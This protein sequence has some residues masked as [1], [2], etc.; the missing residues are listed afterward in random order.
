[1]A[2]D[3]TTASA[4]G[5]TPGF[6]SA[7]AGL[8]REPPTIEGTATETPAQGSAPAAAR[9]PAPSASN[10][11]K[12]IGAGMA[13]SLG[14]AVGAVLALAAT[15]ALPSRDTPPDAAAR[16]AALERKAA[17]PATDPALAK[18]VGEAEATAKAAADAARSAS[19]TAKAA[20]SAAAAAN[21]AAT[22][23]K[24]GLAGTPSVDVAALTRRIEALEQ[25]PT[26]S[27]DPLDAK[28]AQLAQTSDAAAR[29]GAERLSALE[30][31]MAQ[32]GGQRDARLAALEQAQ[33]EMVARADQRVAGYDALLREQS[34]RVDARLSA[35]EATSR[36]ASAQAAQRLAA[37]E[38]GSKQSTDM[39]QARLAAAEAT[40]RESAAQVSQR[41]AALD[42]RIKSLDVKP[43][44]DQLGGLDQKVSTIDGR[45]GAV[46][47][48]AAAQGEELKAVAAGAAQR[49]QSYVKG[50]RS[51]ASALSAEAIQRAVVE[52]RPYKTQLDALA[53]SGVPA[54]ALA[55]LQPYAAGGAPTP[56][57]LLVDFAA[58]APQMARNAAPAEQSTLSERFWS[59]AGRVVQVR[60]V[61]EPGGV[62]AASLTSRIEA[63]LER[64]DVVDAAAAWASLPEP[65]RRVSADFGA[66]LAGVAQAQAA[67]RRL[68]GE[69]Y[70]ALAASPA[71]AKN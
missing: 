57:A 39:A 7:D 54:E 14:G 29:T 59:A 10:G 27:L 68:S 32:V 4:A 51:T 15:Y 18:R 55:P 53:A 8:R 2:D 6:A 21:E 12:T 35:L 63:A 24:A 61:G 9:A 60:K 3:R 69:A 64:G 44:S 16:L 19:E 41:V 38:A 22:A 62:D 5:S 65:A 33:K 1:M 46:E 40:A 17:A 11:S 30:Q 28:V 52:G 25:R 58:V 56:Q 67:A 37:L 20:Q 70:G 26:P 49:E 48:T 43:L 34:S 45:L 71:P 42:E 47:K 31:A 23:A 13:A 50:A 36:D 66:K